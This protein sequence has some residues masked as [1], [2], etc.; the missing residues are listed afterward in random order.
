MKEQ[1]DKESERV[2]YRG[3]WEGVRQQHQAKCSKLAKSGKFARLSLSA[4]P[5]T[6]K[7]SAWLIRWRQWT[8]ESV[9]LAYPLLTSKEDDRVGGVHASRAGEERREGWETVKGLIPSYAQ[10]GPERVN[11][12]PRTSFGPNLLNPRDKSLWAVNWGALCTSV[13]HWSADTWHRHW[14]GLWSYQLFNNHWLFTNNFF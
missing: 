5:N 2:W 3:E 11:N 10:L 12:S 6:N 8:V 13:G 14:Y 7:F 9:W 4:K 1:R